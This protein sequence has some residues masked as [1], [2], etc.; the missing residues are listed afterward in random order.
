MED[1][2]HIA[3]R[4]LADLTDR[5]N[6]LATD[7]AKAKLLLATLIPGATIDDPIN[8]Q[9]PT[10][11]GEVLAV[12]KENHVEISLGTD[13]GL[14]EGNMLEIYRGDKYLGR[15]QL[16]EVQPHRAVGKVLKELQQDVIRDHDQVATRL[17][18]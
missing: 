14:R 3:T 8:R 7:V 15:L 5:N 9:P 6:Q 4:Q 13:D 18:A 17:K 12:D 16:L 1:K 10:V 11:R 2:L